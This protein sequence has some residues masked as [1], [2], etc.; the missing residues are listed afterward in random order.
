MNKINGVSLEEVSRKV[1]DWYQSKDN[2]DTK[3][4]AYHDGVAMYIGI[5]HP[6]ITGVLASIDFDMS[7]QSFIHNYLKEYLKEDN[8]LSK[9]TK[10]MIID[11]CYIGLAIGIIFAEIKIRWTSLLNVMNDDDF[12]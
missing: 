2:E 12:L 4:L 8:E 11:E 1:F 10:E 9:I 7:N 3:C 5:N 6:A